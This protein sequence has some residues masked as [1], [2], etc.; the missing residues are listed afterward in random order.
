M[1]WIGE[2]WVCKILVV[3]NIFLKINSDMVKSEDIKS[4][5]DH[6]NDLSCNYKLVFDSMK[7]LKRESEFQSLI[8][9]SEEYL[10]NGTDRLERI[11]DTYAD[12]AKEIST[13]CDNYITKVKVIEEEDEKEI[14]IIKGDFEK[15]K[16]EIMDM[17][18]V[19][20][21]VKEFDKET[22]FVYNDDK[23]S[24]GL[25]VELV[26][27]YPNSYLYREY[28]SDRRTYD[29]NVFIDCSGENDEFI[30]KYMKDDECLIDD[31]K[32]M[33]LATKEKLLDDLNFLELP[34]K[35]EFVK[36][37]GHNEDNE[38]MEA[39]KN[40]RVLLV[41]N[42]YNK[43]FIELLKKNQLLDTVFKNQNL[44][45]I[46]YIEDQKSFTM[47]ITLKYYDVIVDCLKNGKMIN[48]ELIK[49]NSDNG[50]ADELINEM[51]MIGIELSDDKKEVIKGCFYQPMFMNISKIIDNEEYDKYLQKWTR[52]HK[53]KLIYRASEHR[54][55]AKSFHKYCDNKGPTLIVIKSSEGWIFGG[56]TTQSWSGLSMYN[57]MIFD[58]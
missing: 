50:D 2:V 29:G 9:L 53:W 46:Q 33:N 43:D 3:C 22:Y 18:T 4:F 6:L 32:K 37:L 11:K 24:T 1:K 19:L 51:E 36:E 17:N 34:I 10:K 55:T 38:I 35:K 31:L 7:R 45:R 39:W 52:C 25:N 5:G 48:K 16:G 58:Y 42:E 15:M 47:A 41:N 21:E 12:F 27:Q 54:Y 23:I 14:D 49:A 40:R 13:S 30:V 20:A 28:M 44:G 56:Y 26:K 8:K 57:D